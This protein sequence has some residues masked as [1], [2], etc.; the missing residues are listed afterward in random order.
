MHINDTS[1]LFFKQNY[2]YTV[3]I[4]NLLVRAYE[5]TVQNWQNKEIIQFGLFIKVLDNS[6]KPITENHWR[7]KNTM[8]QDMW[9]KMNTDEE[10]LKSFKKIPN[11][12]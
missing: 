2:S 7:N 6:Y 8:P 5:K 12:K 9:T 11:Q 3:F 10:P 1:F 4:L